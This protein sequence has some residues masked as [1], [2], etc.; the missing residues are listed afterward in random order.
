MP[1]H[2]DKGSN[3]LFS[4]LGFIPPECDFKTVEI[5]NEERFKKLAEQFDYHKNCLV[6]KDSDAHYLGNVSAPVNKLKLD[7]LTHNAV[8]E[9]I[10]NGK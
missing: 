5:N 7:F 8:I 1:A 4:N 6:L 2:I 3:S 10:K 9:K